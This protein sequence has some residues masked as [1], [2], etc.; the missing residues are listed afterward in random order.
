MK[1]RKGPGRNINKNKSNIQYKK[2]NKI[3]AVG[4]EAY[5]ATL[6]FHVLLRLKLHVDECSGTV[7]LSAR[8]KSQV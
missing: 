1:K 6:L 2:H 4:D 3:D 8:K 7:T 5:E